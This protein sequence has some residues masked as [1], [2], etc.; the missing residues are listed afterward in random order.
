MR[1]LQLKSM[2][3]VSHREKKARKI[4]FHPKVTVI[5]GINDTG[6]SSVIKSI[7]YCFGANPHKRHRKWIDADVITLIKFTLDGVAYSIYRHKNS[8]SLFDAS[9]NIIGTY[10]SI[11]NELAPVLAE[12]FN[13]NLKL[14]D[15]DGNAVTPPPAYLLLPF[16]IDQDKGWSDT[17]SSF[18][19]LSQFSHWKPRVTGYHFGVRPD[20]WYALETQKKKAESDRLEPLRQ[21]ASIN[22]IKERALKDLSHIDFDID[23]DSFKNEINSLLEQCNQLKIEEQKFK[24]RLTELKTEKIRLTAQIEIV[25]R[26][27]DELSDDYKYAINH[28]CSTIGCPTCGAEYDNSFTERFEIAQDTETCTDLLVSLRD[29]LT[30]IQRSI[31][32]EEA[33][34]STLSNQQESIRE[35]LAS[36]QGSI[37]LQDLV[38]IE[39][40]KSMLRHLEVEEKEQ[41]KI[42]SNIASTI[43]SISECMEKFDTP[44]R[45]K[46]IIAEY[47]ETLRKYTNKLGVHSLNDNAFKIITSNLDESGSDLPRAI[48]AYFFATQ[49]AIRKNGNST[50]FPIII[51]SPNQQEQDPDNLRKMLEFIYKQRAPEQQLIVGMVEDAGVEFEGEM[52][53]FD[54]KYSVLSEAD[55]LL[56]ATELREYEAANLAI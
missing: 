12:I 34:I 5:K 23:V 50:L 55:Y 22:S 20:K 16:Y 39:G 51:D 43:E 28:D 25:A 52:L 15:R 9:D 21:L 6:K 48:L 26:T 14:S 3:L 27:H 10:S 24:E 36:K 47:G 30:R 37:K 13:F 29:D 49:S 42:L 41:K 40:K 7:P 11:T 4:N 33:F 31:A 19:N 8:F 38:D 53:V 17:W 18:T 32:E 1:N 44:E 45:R 46:E 54:K 2:L 35:L 56:H